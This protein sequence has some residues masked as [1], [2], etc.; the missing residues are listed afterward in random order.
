[1]KRLL[2][3]AA[4]VSIIG[5]GV[6]SGCSDTGGGK[7]A[8]PEPVA[9]AAQAQAQPPPTQYEQIQAA[10]KG[11]Y[12]NPAQCNACVRDQ[13][14]EMESQGE[15][16]Q[17]QGGMLTAAFASGPCRNSC[18]P[19]SCAIEA[20]SCGSI[21]NLCGGTLTCNCTGS[22]VCVNGTC[23]AGCSPQAGLDGPDLVK[24]ICLHPTVPVGFITVCGSCSDQETVCAKACGNCGRSGVSVTSACGHGAAGAC[25]S[26]AVQCSVPVSLLPS[27]GPDLVGCQ[28]GGYQ[29]APGV[30]Y[31]T[32]GSCD[33]PSVACDEVC[34]ACQPVETAFCASPNDSR[35]QPAPP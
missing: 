19:T 21:S 17:S 13:V 20:P 8:A 6:A 26:G 10:C 15:I 35:C 32:C 1:M 30:F 18:I 25:P 3:F 5:L 2:A 33:T 4:C 28:C 22:D 11:S 16:T 14:K 27:L 31:A 23:E 34:A 9:A 24:C 12:A 7:R 29:T